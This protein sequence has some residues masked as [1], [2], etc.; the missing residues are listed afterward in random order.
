LR[1]YVFEWENRN[2]V[3]INLAI[4]NPTRMELETEQA[5]YRMIQEALANVARH[6]QANQVDVFLIFNTKTVEI[7]VQDN[8]IGFN[9]KQ[10]SNGMGLRTIQERAESIGGHANIHSEPG[11][12]TKVLITTPFTGNK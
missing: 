5:I 2:G 1:E 12:G 4:Q 8:G 6:S 9:F 7:T 3:M 10:K 11:K